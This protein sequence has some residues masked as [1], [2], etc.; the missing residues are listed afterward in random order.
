[1]N[2]SEN[3]GGK[4]GG[5]KNQNVDTNSFDLNAKRTFKKVHK[6]I[7]FKAGKIDCYSLFIDTIKNCVENS[8]EKMKILEKEYK[9]DNWSISIIEIKLQNLKI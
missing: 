1:M 3:E 4:K 7:N 2:Q 5:I 8:E 9:K 6:D